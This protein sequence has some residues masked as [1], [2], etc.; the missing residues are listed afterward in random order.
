MIEGSRVI[1]FFY[2]YVSFNL[3]EGDYV[4][5]LSFVVYVYTVLGLFVFR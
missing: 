3:M 5:V 4:S 2:F 1:W